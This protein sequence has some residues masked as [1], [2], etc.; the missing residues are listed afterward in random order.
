MV[1]KIY[2][3]YNVTHILVEFIFVGK[4][5]ST[6]CMYGLQAF[7]SLSKFINLPLK[8]T[9]TVY[10]ATCITVHGIEADIT[11]NLFTQLR[12]ALITHTFRRFLF[13]NVCPLVT[14]THSNNLSSPQSSIPHTLTYVNY[15]HLFLPQFS[16]RTQWCLL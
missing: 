4:S 3:T 7:F 9:K 12:H 14:M 2:K 16:N 8:T 6:E 13:D 11:S 10:P 1:N 15:W 5:T